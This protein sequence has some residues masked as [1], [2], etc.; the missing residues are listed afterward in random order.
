MWLHSAMDLLLWKMQRVLQMGSTAAAKK[1]M[2]HTSKNSDTEELVLSQEYA[3]APEIHRT[4]HHFEH[5]NN[6]F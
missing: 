6:I 5:K 1:H 2:G 4:V 3:P